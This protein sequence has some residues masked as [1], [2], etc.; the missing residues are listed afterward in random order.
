VMVM[1]MVIAVDRDD[2]S[3]ALSECE[4]RR[5]CFLTGG[6]STA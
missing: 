2:N 4:A 1:V 3:D 5:Q 6:W